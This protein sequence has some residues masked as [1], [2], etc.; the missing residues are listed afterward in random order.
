MFL[1]V[2]YPFFIEEIVAE[3]VVVESALNVRNPSQPVRRVREVLYYLI[4]DD[5]A[6]L[7]R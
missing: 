2:E 5:F 4:P 6:L 1:Y 3:E 7:T